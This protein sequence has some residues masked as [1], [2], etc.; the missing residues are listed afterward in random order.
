M[1]QVASLAAHAPGPPRL[2]SELESTKIESGA[3]LATDF[4][5]S[6]L[7]IQLGHEYFAFDLEPVISDGHRPRAESTR[8]PISPQ[9]LAN[10]NPA[11]SRERDFWEDVATTSE[12]AAQLPLSYLGKPPDPVAYAIATVSA[13]Y[14][15]TASDK[16][17][18]NTTTPTAAQP[19]RPPAAQTRDSSTSSQV[20]GKHA[21]HAAN[22]APDLLDA[23]ASL[24]GFED[25]AGLG[26]LGDLD[27]TT[28]SCA[29][30]LAASALAAAV[31]N[32]N[33]AL[34]AAEGRRG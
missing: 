32:R 19:V 10:T 34:K 25:I 31:T 3:I 11:Q 24:L 22:E 18:A 15:L 29:R 26:A 6:E 16:R 1:S 28:F 4:V 27:P 17:G 9:A 30:E 23:L 8:A 14:T 13:S 33:S 7:L 5:A 12:K 2:D 21:H 20:T